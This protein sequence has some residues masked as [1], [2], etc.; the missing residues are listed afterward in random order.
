MPTSD[1]DR[2]GEGERW[3]GV[4]T[5]AAG[6]RGGSP[7]REQGGGPACDSGAAGARPKR[8]RSVRGARPPAPGTDGGTPA[9]GRAGGHRGESPL[10]P[11]VFSGPREAEKQ[12]RRS[13]A[14]R[15]E[16]TKK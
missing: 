11:S 2:N 5:R 4:K 8:E 14:E 12:L 10:I 9:Q 7:A 13:R 3:V 6:E 15:R 16:G 1:A